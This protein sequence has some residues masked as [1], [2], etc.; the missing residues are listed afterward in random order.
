MSLICGCEESYSCVSMVTQI[1]VWQVSGSC[2]VI[3][4]KESETFILEYNS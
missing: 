1:N 3:P 2:T 4:V